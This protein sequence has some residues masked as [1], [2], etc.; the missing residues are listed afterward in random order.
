MRLRHALASFP[1]TTGLLVGLLIEKRL[2]SS[3]SVSCAA[4]NAELKTTRYVFWRDSYSVFVQPKTR[5]NTVKKPTLNPI[6][7]VRRES[8]VNLDHAAFQG[9]K[10][11]Y[12]TCTTALSLSSP[13][14]LASSLPPSRPASPLGPAFPPPRRLWFRPSDSF[15]LPHLFLGLCCNG[16]LFRSPETSLPQL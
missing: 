11:K 5:G 4:C 16:S 9:G 13:T 3:F 2:A 15:V 12:R 7:R 6:R 14:K 10:S 1:A 8:W